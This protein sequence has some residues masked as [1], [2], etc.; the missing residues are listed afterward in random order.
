MEIV[1]LQVAMLL[2]NKGLY[3]KQKNRKALILF[4]FWE[5]TVSLKLSIQ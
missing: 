1:D 2:L 5:G 3:W 4:Q